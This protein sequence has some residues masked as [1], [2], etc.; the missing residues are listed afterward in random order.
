MVLAQLTFVTAVAPY[1]A[2][3][4]PSVRAQVSHQ[5][6]ACAHLIIED[7]ERRGPGAARNAGLL[8]AQ[9]PFVAFLDADDQ[10]AE[11][12]AAETMAAY[13]KHGA[14]IHHHRCPPKG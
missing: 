5:T 6:V 8:K 9:T 2:H 14:L 11:T 1:H 12:W 3:L 4:I 13:D 7:R 10:I